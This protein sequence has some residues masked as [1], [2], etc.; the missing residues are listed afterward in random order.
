[1]S[2]LRTES[3]ETTQVQKEDGASRLH[4][5][6]KGITKMATLSSFKHNSGTVTI[7]AN[8]VLYNKT[9]LSLT[10]GKIC[11][12]TKDFG[13]FFF[14]S[15]IF[16]TNFWNYE[17]KRFFL[18]MFFCNTFFPRPSSNAPLWRDDTAN[19]S[20]A[21]AIRRTRDT[22][23]ESTSIINDVAVLRDGPMLLIAEIWKL[24]PKKPSL[25]VIGDS[26][27]KATAFI[28]EEDVHRK[29]SDNELHALLTSY[30]T[31]LFGVDQ[32]EKY[33]TK[34]FYLEFVD[35][36]LKYTTLS[37]TEKTPPD[38][39]GWKNGDLRF[40]LDKS[41]FVYTAQLSPVNKNLLSVERHVVPYHQPTF[42]NVE[43]KVEIEMP[44]EAKH[45][46]QRLFRGNLAYA[47]IAR[48]Y[49]KALLLAD[50]EG[51]QY[52]SIL[53]IYGPGNTGKSALVKFLEGLV[54]ESEKAHM[55]RTTS[56]FANAQ[57]EKAKL[58]V[59]DDVDY[60]KKSEAS[61]FRP[62][63]GKDKIPTD[64]KYKDATLITPK[65]VTIIV[66][67]FPPQQFPA[68]REPAILNKINKVQLRKEHQVTME[69]RVTG[70][71]QEVLLYAQ[72]IV[73]WALYTPLTLS[74]KI[75][76]GEFWRR[77]NRH[78]KQL[79]GLDTGGLVNFV[80]ENLLAQPYSSEDIGIGFI[81]GN[82]LEI[83]VRA[84]IDKSS[85]PEVQELFQ[86]LPE[87]RRTRE[88]QMAILECLAQEFDFH[89]AEIGRFSKSSVYATRPMGLK[90]LIIKPPGE[91]IPHGAKTFQ[92]KREQDVAFTTL[93]DWFEAE[94]EIKS[95]IGHN[96]NS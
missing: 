3:E 85:D 19:W 6:P 40:V 27:K 57:L 53:Y 32:P 77:Y 2:A 23:L 5:S 38:G 95:I 55:L 22:Q 11:T 89:D 51:D 63:A 16:S 7:D 69:E 88:L 1:M 79:E 12:Q 39:R 20:C 81:P 9:V 67:N 24:D 28:L 65:C 10:T 91:S 94:T 64:V 86:S 87:K 30:V 83:C 71:E 34:A 33:A 41:K 78:Q 13:P 56:R 70:F 96:R 14:R 35:F 25:I 21:A 80:E 42:N 93:Q 66:S 50:H 18:Q 74:A 52:Q 59:V 76:R 72:H 82:D 37:L 26:A 48:A 17:R 90:N 61:F 29:L 68:L 75:I 60:L 4:L 54:L 44:E 45:M 62:L 31:D 47:S 46:I 36:L 73:N 84:Y 8:C 58:F 92:L 49:I 43:G 15:Q